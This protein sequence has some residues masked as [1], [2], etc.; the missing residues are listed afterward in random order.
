MALSRRVSP[1][2]AARPAPAATDRTLPDVCLYT[3]S[4]NASGMGQHMLDLAEVYVQRGGRVTFMGW[5]TE[6]GRRFLD[7]ARFLGAEPVAIPHPRDP[8][9]ASAIEH[10]LRAHPV[11]VFH[12]HVGTGREDFDGARAARSA[13]VPAVVETVHLPWRIRNKHKRTPFFRSIADV[14]RLVAVSHGQRRSYERIGVPGGRFTTVPNGV[15]PRSHVLGRAAARERLG[16]DADRPVVMSVGRLTVM[17]GQRHLVDAM[18]RLLAEHPDLAVVLIGTGELR[19]QLEKQAADLGVASSLVLAGHRPDAR[20]LLDAAD[21]F[22]LPSRHEGMPLAAM[23]ALEAG[24]PVVGTRVIGTEE[25][26][27]HGVTGSLVRPRDPGQL[28]EALGLLLADAD[29]RRAQGRAA[30]AA[31]LERFTAAR[32]AADTLAVYRRVLADA[33]TGAP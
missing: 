15:R 5:P 3:P 33:A 12:V 4:A 13:G 1:S 10:R 16:L 30:R 9:F 29:L 7:R 24:L 18:P 8:G 2:A 23:E 17:K 26:V 14:D 6:A 28:A 20:A 11:E 31:Y 25:V 21:V 32:M 22:V 27:E 19:E